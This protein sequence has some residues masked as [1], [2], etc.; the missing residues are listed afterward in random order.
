MDLAHASK[1]ATIVETPS[2]NVVRHSKV[3]KV[4]L[5]GFPVGRFEVKGSNRLEGDDVEVD[6]NG[7][8]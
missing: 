4:L 2:V 3:A 6:S 8:Q 5:V 1:Y 7:E